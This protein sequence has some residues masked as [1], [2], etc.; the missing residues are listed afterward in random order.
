APAGIFPG[1]PQ[2]NPKG[3]ANAIILRSGT[4]VDGPA[5]PMTKDSTKQPNTDEP[6]EKQGEPNEEEKKESGEKVVEKKRPYV[7]PPP[8]KPPIPV[9][10]T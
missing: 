1:Q 4:Q 8:Y 5:D 7:P 2:Q 3:Q 9:S 10:Y 6:I